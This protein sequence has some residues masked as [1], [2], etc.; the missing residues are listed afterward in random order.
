[1]S[2]AGL[3]RLLEDIYEREGHLPFRGECPTCDHLPEEPLPVM[4]SEFVPGAPEV[5]DGLPHLRA[6][7]GGGGGRRRGEGSDLRL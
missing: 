5:Q 4:R 7:G 2:L 3:V 6:Q 1:M